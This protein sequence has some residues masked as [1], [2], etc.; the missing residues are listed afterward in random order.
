MYHTEPKQKEFYFESVT[1]A[2]EFA[3][4]KNSHET[5]YFW[6]VECTDV[7]VF[8]RE[9]YTVYDSRDKK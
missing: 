1:T 8:G 6:K 5:D 3:Q 4:W 9:G 2:R 7:R